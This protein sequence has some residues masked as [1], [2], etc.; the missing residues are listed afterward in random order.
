VLDAEQGEGEQCRARR[1][2]G[3]D[4]EAQ[5]DGAQPLEHALKPSART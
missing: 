4:G 2:D 3:R 1:Q 5:R